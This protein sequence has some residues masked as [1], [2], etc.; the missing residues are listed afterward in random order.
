MKKILLGIIT[1]L[2]IT[3]SFAQTPNI[4]LVKSFNIGTEVLNYISTFD[5]YLVYSLQDQVILLNLLTLKETRIPVKSL[6]AQN[7]KT[8]IIKFKILPNKNIA[9]INNEP[10][11]IFYNP[12]QNSKIELPFNIES[13][14]KTHNNIFIY[15]KEN[16]EDID[17]SNTGKYLLIKKHISKLFLGLFPLE[18]YYEYSLLVYPTLSVFYTFS[19]KEISINGSIIFS[20]KDK[21]LFL[22]NISYSTLENKT[23]GLSIL[24]L[25]NQRLYNLFE[26]TTVI[27]LDT[28]NNDELIAISTEDNYFKVL[29]SR[30]FKE[31]FSYKVSG[32][33][34]FSSKNNLL[35][36]E[37]GR[38]INIFDIKNREL[39]SSYLGSNPCISPNQNY[40]AYSIGKNFASLT[41]EIVIVNRYTNLQR[42]ITFKEEYFLEDIKFSKDENF[43]ILMLSGK[44]GYKIEIY[45]I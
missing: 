33:I 36:V 13:N 20:K 6:K 18:D 31:I 12:Y 41:K 37:G 34:K 28:T 19:S 21:F 1:F 4:S 24:D 38:T 40:I 23:Y 42:S 15:Q 7:L 2:T 30:S 43:L 32:Y 25:R 26:N 35:I 11:I 10:F 16:I 5:N 14:Q 39:I 17:I 45:K 27:D 3:S 29:S 8:H 44:D 22:T 9:I